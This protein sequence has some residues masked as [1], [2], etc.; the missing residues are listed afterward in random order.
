[1]DNRT[2][3]SINSGQ[4]SIQ[5]ARS[6]WV[7]VALAAHCAVVV[8]SLWSGTKVLAL[9]PRYAAE[10]QLTQIAFT[11]VLEIGLAGLALLG[12]WR[13]RRWGWVLALVLDGFF[14]V[15]ALSWVIQFP[16]LVPR[17]IASEIWEFIAL[18]I[19]LHR[20]VRVHFAGGAG[21]PLKATLHKGTTESATIFRK[22]VYFSASAFVTCFVT[23][24]AVAVWIGEKAGGM[25]GFKVLLLFGFAIGSASAL[26]FTL[27]LTFVVRRLDPLKLSRWLLVGG[28]L[29]PALILGLGFLVFAASAL[30]V[31]ASGAFA[32]PAYLFQVWW[33]A[34]PAG[35]VA[36]FIC[37]QLY[38]WAFRQPNSSR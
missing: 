21:S 33:L 9:W 31:S 25:A 26:L 8:T 10:R 16:M 6:Q 32:G 37:G 18:A 19:L 20:P 36:A 13:S 27:I 34:V 23:T 30:G 5:Q 35:L 14:C 15:R 28:V 2:T 7:W 1:M 12:L 4:S 24:L 38:P 29:A 17:W 3:K 11:T 22:L